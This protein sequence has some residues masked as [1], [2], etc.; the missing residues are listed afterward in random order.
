MTEVSAQRQQDRRATNSAFLKEVVSDIPGWLYDFT[1]SCAMELLDLQ[2]ESGWNGSLLEIGVYAGRF[3]SI[4]AR[5]AFCRGSRLLGIDPFTHFGVEEVR[6]R[7]QSLKSSLTELAGDPDPEAG[8]SIMLVEDLSGNWTADRLL[9]S[10]GGSARFIHIDAS[11]D[12]AD[13][14]WDLHICDAALAPTGIIAV[15]DW[16]N[17]QCLG[18]MEATFQFFQQQPRASVP[19]ALTPGKLL[20]CG[21]ANAVSYQQRLV[22]FATTDQ[23]FPQSES[24]RQRSSMKNSGTKQPLFGSEILVLW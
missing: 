18:V 7:L 21:R 14:L 20:L 1:A 4:L 19:F 24:F 5:D 3:C 12:R 17:P 11:H 23:T 16:L 6:S 13:V 10:L 9:A 22:E 2:E 8:G 15:D